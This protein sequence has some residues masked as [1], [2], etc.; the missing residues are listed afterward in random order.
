MIDE[1]LDIIQ[2]RSRNNDGA[3]VVGEGWYQQ[4]S[5]VDDTGVD[6]IEEPRSQEL[7][8]GINEIH[9][10]TKNAGKLDLSSDGTV[11]RVVSRLYGALD[12]GEW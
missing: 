8:D 4:V 11:G 12:I 3:R 2:Q 5:Q 7:S 10:I 1:R 9:M 6:I